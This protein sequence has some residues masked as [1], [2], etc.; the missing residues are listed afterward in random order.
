[1]DFN[2]DDYV[3]IYLD[4]FWEL[5][6]QDSV[7]RYVC[8]GMGLTLRNT[9]SYWPWFRSYLAVALR[10]ITELHWPSGTPTKRN[11]KHNRKYWKYLHGHSKPFDPTK[12]LGIFFWT[13]S[14]CKLEWF[15]NGFLVI[16]SY[17]RPSCIQRWGSGT[18]PHEDPWGQRFTQAHQPHRARLA[19]TRLCGRYCFALDG[20]QGDA[21]FIAALFQLKRTLLQ[22]KLFFQICF[23][24]PSSPSCS[25]DWDSQVGYQS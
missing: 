10:W 17:H 18:H 6:T 9:S 15:T 13:N 16:R 1:M 22:P 12:C 25:L 5:R 2:D 8:M 4:H 11:Q 20:I 23:G 3:F 19:G 24:G 7:Y 14:E 21:D